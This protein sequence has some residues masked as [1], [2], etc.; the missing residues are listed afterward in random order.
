MRSPTASR[1]SRNGS[2]PS[3]QLGRREQSA[4][5][6]EPVER[7][8]L[9]RRDALGEE[10]LGESR[11][12]V[13]LRPQVVELGVA[14]AEP[15]EALG[16]VH[17]PTAR[18]VGANRLLGASAD[19]LVDRHSERLAADVPQR[20]VEGGQ[21]AQLH[22]EPTPAGQVVGVQRVP[23]AFHVER[24]LPQQDGCGVVVNVRGDRV[25][26]VVR[27]ARAHQALVGRYLDEDEVREVGELEGS[28]SGDLHGLLLSCGSLAAPRRGS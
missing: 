9:H 14:F 28:D 26:R 2:M 17:R 3:R 10:A 19:Q 21:G 20:H 4:G 5:E 15:V 7:P 13:D 23:V 24:V 1:I 16:S 22:T 12:G 27:V 18:V 11:R 25:G 8:D 6:R